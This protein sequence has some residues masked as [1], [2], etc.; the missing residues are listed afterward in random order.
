MQGREPRTR[1]EWLLTRS[2]LVIESLDVHD[3]ALRGRRRPGTP[4]PPTPSRRRR[5]RPPRPPGTNFVWRRN[6]GEASRRPRRASCCSW[7]EHC[8]QKRRPRRAPRH[9][10]DQQECRGR[11]RPKM[12]EWD[13]RGGTRPKK[14]GVWPPRRLA[15]RAF[16]PVQMT[17]PPTGTNGTRTTGPRPP[18]R[19]SR[20]PSP[21]GWSTTPLPS[22]AGQINA[23]DGGWDDSLGAGATSSAPASPPRRWRPSGT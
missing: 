7:G 23:K 12:Q 19:R 15:P 2:P 9:P 22:P 8:P 1:Q 21:S 10:P 6:A 4:H 18:T 13:R 16:S 5:H 11:C 20:G 17:R 14:Q 3:P